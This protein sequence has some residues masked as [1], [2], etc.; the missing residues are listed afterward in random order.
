MTSLKFGT[1]GLRGLVTELLG[2][3][4]YVW[5]QAFCEVMR[6]GGVTGAVMVGRDL[7]DSSPGIAALCVQAI[8][9]A[10]FAPV[11][12]G[13]VPTPA[14]ALAAMAAGAPAVMVTGSHIPEDRN[15]LKFYR[16]DGEINKGDEALVSAWQARL[17][18]TEAP[19]V[20]ARATAHDAL[21]PYLDRYAAFFGRD[22]LR[23]M[24][25]GVYQHSSV[26][27]DVMCDVL[28]AAGAT[29]VPLGRASSFIPV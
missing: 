27:R 29:P 17:D 10:G 18:I 3:P 1:S 5:T 28:R 24:T 9:D 13:A 14:L 7:R 26:G 21:T 19:A 12:C 23:G 22:A 4:A 15:G 25:V 8:A 11:D 20:T 2:L 6:E 16:P